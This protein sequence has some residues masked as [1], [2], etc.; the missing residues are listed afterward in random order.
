M[1]EAALFIDLDK[2]DASLRVRLLADAVPRESVLVA[3]PKG[4]KRSWSGCS[5]AHSGSPRLPKTRIRR[6][7]SLPGA[8]WLAQSAP[9]APPE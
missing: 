6:A 9:R 4:E 3:F 1:Q 5:C 8:T 2:T 7:F